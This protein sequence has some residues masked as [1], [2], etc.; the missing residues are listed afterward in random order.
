MLTVTPRE[1]YRPCVGVLLFNPAGLVW[2]GRRI[3]LPE[4]P[5]QMPQGGIDKGEAPEEAALRELREETGTDKALIVGE[6]Q[7]WL[8]Y[9]LPG[10]ARSPDGGKAWGGKWRG[11]TQKWFACRFIG[12][13]SD[14]NINDHDPEFDSWRWAEMD[15]VPGLIVE[16]KRAVYA[17]AVAEL[18]PMVRLALANDWTRPGYG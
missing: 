8:S 3:G 5:W 11:Q 18:K 9:D 4:H 16:F 12:E 14:F 1:G 15:E 17:E 13:D 10:W 7:G 6:T 2:I